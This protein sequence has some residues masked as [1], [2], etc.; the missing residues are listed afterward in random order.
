MRNVKE[1]KAE[2]KTL[3]AN[4][5]KFNEMANEGKLTDEDYADLH[6]MVGWRDALSWVLTEVP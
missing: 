4:I 2:I 1:L 5:S 6:E 3:T